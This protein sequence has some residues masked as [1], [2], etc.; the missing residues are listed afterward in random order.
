MATYKLI[1]DNNES[2]NYIDKL[3][4][5]FEPD[6]SLF[7]DDEPETSKEI[8]LKYKTIFRH[9]EYMYTVALVRDMLEL[10]L[11][12]LSND[13][14]CKYDYLNVSI[15][16]LASIAL[17]DKKIDQNDDSHIKNSIQL[18]LCVCS[19]INELKLSL[20]D[21]YNEEV[22]E[23]LLSTIRLPG[24][25]TKDR[26]ILSLNARL[27]VKTENTVD[28]EI[29]ALVDAIAIYRERSK[30]NTV[31]YT[32]EKLLSQK[33]FANEANLKILKAGGFSKLQY[34][35]IENEDAYQ[36]I[37][38]ENTTYIE[39]YDYTKDGSS[40]LIYLK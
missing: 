17:K 14:S 18:L 1:L 11:A 20:D 30:Q 39:G 33:V 23:K 13:G 5:D 37:K 25:L 3:Y 35:D 29:T 34:F 22:K 31:P 27:T 24:I 10:G 28:E 36:L 4:L 6:I 7:V 12:Y 2:N 9:M 16:Y 26:F 15:H 32:L 19:K 21:L 8:V 38:Q 40:C